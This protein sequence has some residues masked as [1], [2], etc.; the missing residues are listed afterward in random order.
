MAPLKVLCEVVCSMEALLS[1]HTSL[2][3]FRLM[4]LAQE[5]VLPTFTI[6]LLFKESFQQ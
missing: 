2:L 1:K 3:P 6:Y 5:T 4:Q